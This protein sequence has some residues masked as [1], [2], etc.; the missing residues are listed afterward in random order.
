LH[1]ANA[2]DIPGDYFHAVVPSAWLEVGDFNNEL[3]FCDF[4]FLQKKGA[5]VSDV[6]LRIAGFP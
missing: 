3:V 6:M 5:V 2:V 4:G 1:S